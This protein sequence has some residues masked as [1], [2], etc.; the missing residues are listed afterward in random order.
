VTEA[1]KVNI[2]CPHGNIVTALVDPILGR[3]EVP[4]C[5]HVPTP[6][7]PGRFRVWF[8]VRKARKALRRMTHL[9]D[10]DAD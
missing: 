9:G 1:F 8:Q 7:K 10:L 5:D 2:Y 4:T 3:I 6:R